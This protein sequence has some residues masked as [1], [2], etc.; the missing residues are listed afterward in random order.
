[1]S[2]LAYSLFLV[3]CGWLLRGVLTGAWRKVKSPHRLGDAAHYWVEIG[4]ETH[5]FTSEQLAAAYARAKRLTNPRKKWIHASAWIVAL[6]ALVAIFTLSGCGDSKAI[7]SSRSKPTL[8]AWVGHAGKSM[9]PAFPEFA[10]VEVEF[11][12]PY[13]SLKEG[14]TVIFWDYTRATPL[15][16]HHRLVAK[17]A[18]AWIAQGDNAATNATADRPWVTPD[19]YIARTTGKHTQLLSAPKP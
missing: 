10:L 7:P 2:T 15:L 11:G 14:D 17:Q 19:N 8:K 6:A 16:I 12:V 1:M 3:A 4:G 5:A 9:L 18:N 13:E